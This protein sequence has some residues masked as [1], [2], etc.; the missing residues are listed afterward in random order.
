M[1]SLFDEEV[2]VIERRK[3]FHSTYDLL[4]LRL[5]AKSVADEVLGS[6]HDPKHG[7]EHPLA[8]LTVAG[9]AWIFNQAGGRTSGNKR[10][11]RYPHTRKGDTS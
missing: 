10:P 8:A 5:N 4:R 9:I 7:P 6:F 2:E 3:Q 1:K 11:I